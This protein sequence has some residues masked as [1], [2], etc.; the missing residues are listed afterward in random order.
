M[1]DIV[2]NNYEKKIN[3][4]CG[5]EQVDAKVTLEFELQLD[6]FLALQVLNTALVVES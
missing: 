2:A 4:E 1:T 3:V 6:Y 5:G